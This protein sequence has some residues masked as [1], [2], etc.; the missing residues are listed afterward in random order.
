MFNF[1]KNK[2]SL[3]IQADTKR[4]FNSKNFS[5]FHNKLKSIE[6]NKFMQVHPNYNDIHTMY[7][8]FEQEFI[9]VFKSAFPT[10][11]IPTANCSNQKLIKPWLSS[12]IIKSCKKKN[13]LYYKYKRYPSVPNRLKYQNY[14]KLLQI[15]I[16]KAEQNY[17]SREFKNRLNNIKETWQ[18]INFNSK[19]KY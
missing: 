3:S 15:T 1:E 8:D 16:R 14:N 2:Q 19:Q 9:S 13:K 11:K 17:Y 7:N 5:I 4:I 18:L 10:I 12:A 6:W